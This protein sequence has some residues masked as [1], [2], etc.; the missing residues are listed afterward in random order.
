MHHVVLIDLI[1]Y[2]LKS[3]SFTLLGFDL[4]AY[5]A[6]IPQGLLGIWSKEVVDLRQE[7]RH[8]TGT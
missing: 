6:R 2:D 5:L 3:I 7:A 8:G 1:C 4:Q